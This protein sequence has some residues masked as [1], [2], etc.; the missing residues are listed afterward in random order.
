MPEFS[1]G[2]LGEFDGSLCGGA[3]EANSGDLI[4]RIRIEPEARPGDALA[5]PSLSATP[6]PTKGMKFE[7]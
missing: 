1:L 7:Q 3:F 2:N 4:Q 6:E 5:D